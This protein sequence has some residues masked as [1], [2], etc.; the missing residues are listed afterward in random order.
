MGRSAF[1]G[2]MRERLRDLTFQINAIKDRLSDGLDSHRKGDMRGQ[3]AVLEARRD[4]MELKLHDLEEE[5]DG[6]WGDL[7]AEVETEWDDLVQDF[8]ERLGNLA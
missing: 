4:Q 5:P 1:T 6:T 8:E 2:A 7:K 3:L